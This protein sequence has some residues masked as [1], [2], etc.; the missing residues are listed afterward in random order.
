MHRGGIL[1]LWAAAVLTLYTGFSYVQANLSH[2]SGE[3]A[4]PRPRAAERTS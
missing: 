2:V 4:R 3:H 1:T